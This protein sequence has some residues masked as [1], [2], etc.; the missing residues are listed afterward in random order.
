MAFY[1]VLGGNQPGKRSKPASVAFGSTAPLFP[2]SIKLP[3]EDHANQAQAM[4]SLLE[5]IGFDR[6][7]QDIGKALYES[8]SSRSILTSIPTWYSFR[9]GPKIRHMIFSDYKNDVAPIFHDSDNNSYRSAMRTTTTLTDALVFLIMGVTKAAQDEIWPLK[10]PVFLPALGSEPKA[11]GSLQAT[12]KK[13]SDKVVK[14]EATS[15]R[16]TTTTVRNVSDDENE[17]EPT[18]CTDNVF[19]GAEHRPRP[20]QSRSASPTKSAR[21][22]SP[23]KAAKGKAKVPSSPSTSTL[24]IRLPSPTQPPSSPVKPKAE[25]RAESPQKAQPSSSQQVD[26][27]HS[28]PVRLNRDVNDL[29][30]DYLVSHGYTSSAVL[31]IMQSFGRTQSAEEFAAQMVTCGPAFIYG[32]MYFFLIFSNNVKQFYSDNMSEPP[33]PPLPSRGLQWLNASTRKFKSS[34]IYHPRKRAVKPGFKL[35]SVVRTARQ[36][37]NK[38]RKLDILTHQQEINRL[39]WAKAELLRETHGRRSVERYYEDLI[40]FCHVDKSKRKIS[41]WNAFLHQES[42]KFPNDTVPDGTSRATAADHARVL[43]EKWK[44]MTPDER[45]AVTA[46]AR[47]S[48]QVQR[49]NKQQGERQTAFSAFHDAR[50]V[51]ERMQHDLHALSCRSGVETALFVSRSSQD[52]HYKPLAYCSSDAVAGFFTF[53]FKQSPPELACRMEG[54]ILSGVDGA[55]RKHTNNILD[56]K[57]RTVN[58]IM[59]KLREAARFEVARMYYSNFDENIT[60]KYG[61]KVIGWPLDKFCSP[62]DLTSRVEVLLLF[63]AWESGTARFYKMTTQELE[64]WDQARFNERMRDTVTD[65]S[66]SSGGT[67]TTSMPNEPQLMESI[68]WPSF[69]GSLLAELHA[70]DPM[71][72]PPYDLTLPL[73]GLPEFT[74]PP[75]LFQPPNPQQPPVPPPSQSTLRVINFSTVSSSS[76]APLAVVSKPRKQRSDKGKKRGPRKTDQ[77][78]EEDPVEAAAHDRARFAPRRR[79]G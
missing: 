74:F 62:S 26:R 45:L 54:Y 13:A 19:Q 65:P 20:S 75:P 14:S 15:E 58:L 1:F 55:V 46:D 9:T 23:M 39:I 22:P 18:W 51:I 2:I 77:N 35:P 28:S 63:R 32:E 30:Q 66:T 41:S 57:K 27:T 69:E 10:S 67:G 11:S 76:G 3:S 42:K 71:D 60:A 79:R 24:F 50:K 5:Q 70:T 6:P 73:P 7:R 53:Y 47:E 31:E 56:L 12:K 72:W 68:N 33:P 29:A 38:K 44:G 8:R 78:D 61:V 52:H 21:S 36:V 16:K 40:K 37:E 48:L 64:D 43:K 4:Q 49:D 34:R 17:S 59:S 25:A